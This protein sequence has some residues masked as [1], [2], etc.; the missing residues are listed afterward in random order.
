MEH[1]ITWPEVV[2]GVL[3]F[4]ALTGAWAIVPLLFAM[5]IEAWRDRGVA[6]AT[7]K[8]ARRWQEVAPD[9][10]IAT[11]AMALEV[12]LFPPNDTSATTQPLHGAEADQLRLVLR[13][14]QAPMRRPPGEKIAGID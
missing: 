12:K 10:R 5:A 3:I 11:I 4:L 14:C 1:S 2:V 6:R 8:S 9:M 7:A 13:W